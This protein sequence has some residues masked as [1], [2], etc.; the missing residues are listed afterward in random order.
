[1]ARDS[2]SGHH[3]CC[4][5]PLTT[6]PYLIFW[7]TQVAAAEAAAEGRAEQQRRRAPPPNP[8]M[9]ARQ[10]GC[11][12]WYADFAF[13]GERRAAAV[14][15]VHARA[16]QQKAKQQQVEQRRAAE[17]NSKVSVGESMFC[18]DS[19]IPPPSFRRRF[20]RADEGVPAN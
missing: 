15:G 1:M 3:S 16:K 17:K 8:D 19:A 6:V 9:P 5:R 7:T 20:N 4:D 18:H 12:G 10:P 11:T 14:K 2:S 13:P